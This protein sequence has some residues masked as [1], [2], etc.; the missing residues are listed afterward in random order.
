MAN[1]V[2]TVT[3]D[4]QAVSAAFALRLAALEKTVAALG[5]DAQKTLV[6]ATN[7]L[8][9][10]AAEGTTV[11]AEALAGVTAGI[12]A[13]STGNVVQAAVDIGGVLA[14]VSSATQKV[15]DFFKGVV[16]GAKGQAAS[17]GASGAEQ[18]GDALGEDGRTIFD[19]IKDAIT[20]NTPPAPANPSGAVGG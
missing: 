20:G 4:A 5:A 17:A 10:I 2:A 14:P 11:G 1:V 7:D 3:S 16:E 15:I 9:A 6:D 18:A 19:A 13:A 8:V 12:A